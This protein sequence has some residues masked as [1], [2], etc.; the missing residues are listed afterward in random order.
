MNPSYLR[1]A[2][3]ASLLGI[4]LCL[5]ATAQQR[6]QVSTVKPSA[7][8]A[9]RHTQIRGSRFVSEGTTLEDLIKFAYGVHA[10]QIIAGPAW[11]HT[12]KF[13]TMADPE[14]EKRPSPEEL[15]AM[16]AELL[17]NRFQLVLVHEQQLIPVF[18]LQR[19]SKE[20]KLKK[21]DSPD[22]YLSGGLTPPGSLF[23]GHGTVTDF[24]HFLQRYAPPEI[25]RP[26]VDQTGIQGHYDFELHFTPVDAPHDAQASSQTNT[27][28][29]APNIF[30][31]IQEQLGLRLKPTRA[32]TE[33]LRVAS[34]SQPTPN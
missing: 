30:T 6:Y 20:P 1:S 27:P 28:P 2:R 22:V 18:A 9:E 13:D 19:T 16:V 34:V 15:R 23:V 29:E 10:T 3:R 5:A 26:I 25:D 17:A 11:I 12:Q 4:I 21:D 32:A 24:T 14:T 31:A 7:P 33:V 8:E